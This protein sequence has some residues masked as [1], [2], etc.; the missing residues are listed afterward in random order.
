MTSPQSPKVTVF[1]PVHN[2][3]RYIGDTI[4]SILAQH[5]QDFDLL[6]IDDGSTDRSVEVMRS[7]QD[8]RITIVYNETNQGIPRTR[9][10]GLDLAR[11]E[12]IALLDSDDRARPDRLKK[13][14]AYLDT[15]PECVQVGSWSRMMNEQG[16]PLRRIKRQPAH[17]E[18]IKAELLF[19]CCMSNRTI[20]GRTDIFRQF[21]YRNDFSRC[22]DYDLH[23]R[24]ASRFQMA[25]IPE[26]LVL[27]RIHAQQITT[28]TPV[29]GDAKKRQIIGAQL[30]HLGVSFSPEDLD[31][32]LMLSRM[33][34]MQFTPDAAYRRWTEA[35]LLRLLQANRLTRQYD[36]RA[37]SKVLLMKWAYTCWVSRKRLGIG[38][39]KALLH[40]ILTRELLLNQ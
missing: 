16:I 30:H 25:N 14:V 7:F 18:E 21:G 9:N 11:G 17:P 2:R 34:K 39:I 4:R 27:G 36:P 29:L 38:W 28:L 10:R 13:Q 35:W 15:H 20:M 23:V 22:Q 12:Y 19:R 32:H 8:P 24:L 3:E 26:C 37:Y 40:S 6:L 31:A 33:R 5:F 1:I